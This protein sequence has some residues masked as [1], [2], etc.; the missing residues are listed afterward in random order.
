MAALILVFGY[1]SL[2]Q[3][4]D[5]SAQRHFVGIAKCK[6]A[7]TGIAAPSAVSRGQVEIPYGG[8]CRVGRPGPLRYNRHL[9][10]D[11]LPR[12]FQA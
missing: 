12:R 1:S 10:P 4:R 8:E 7:D 9:R 6:V 5:K 3:R 11:G 2:T